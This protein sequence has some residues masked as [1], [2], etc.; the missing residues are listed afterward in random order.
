MHRTENEASHLFIIEIYNSYKMHFITIKGQFTSGICSLRRL[1]Y[2][3]LCPVSYLLQDF[4]M[5]SL[6]NLFTFRVPD[7]G[8]SSKRVMHT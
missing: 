2:T 4:S 1:W 3:F 8:Y 5:I 7:E 6:F